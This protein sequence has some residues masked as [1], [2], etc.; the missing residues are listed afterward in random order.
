MTQY[1]RILCHAWIVFNNDRKS[2]SLRLLTDKN[3]ED[4]LLYRC[5]IHMQHCL[6]TAIVDPLSPVGGR[7]VHASA[8]WTHMPELIV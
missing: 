4:D 6:S 1:E 3:I 2:E 8:F 5:V 7:C